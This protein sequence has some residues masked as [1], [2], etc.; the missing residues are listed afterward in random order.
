MTH[1]RLENDKPRRNGDVRQHR[2][3]RFATAPAALLALALLG[4]THTSRADAPSERNDSASK[5]DSQR[6]APVN[7]GL[8]LAA[9]VGF[10][11]DSGIE[12]TRSEA[13]ASNYEEDPFGPALAV[14]AAY[15]FRPGLVLG[16]SLMHHLGGSRSP[17]HEITSAMF[18]AGWAFPVGPL[19]LEP[20]VG[21][22]PSWLS[23]TVKLCSTMTGACSSSS[24][25][26]A[27]S[28]ATLGLAVT[29]PVSKR[30]F[31]G[32]RGQAL[33]I[34]GPTLGFTVFAS[35]GMRF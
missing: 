15:T 29:A 35:T 16:V 34:V 18:E 7:H 31:V 28:S 3:C 12:F 21:F 22:G 33:A 24:D 2:C 13:G 17:E 23:R 26:D 30:F 10:G 9:L 1:L 4:V 20:F 14:R 27:A 11:R 8:S 5:G 19:A 32:A 25:S 6:L